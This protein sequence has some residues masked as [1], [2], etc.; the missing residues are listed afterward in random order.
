MRHKS[1]PDNLPLHH[2]LVRQNKIDGLPFIQRQQQGLGHRIVPVV[3]F[4]DLQ[5]SPAVQRPQDY[6]VGLQVPGNIRYLHMIGALLQAQRH[7]LPHHRELLVVN[8]QGR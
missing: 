2:L 4:Q 3:L 8:R 6:R 5:S 1:A 7:G